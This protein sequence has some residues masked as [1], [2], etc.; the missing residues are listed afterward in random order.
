MSETD[1]H[2]P[3]ASGGVTAV[4]S[5][6]DKLVPVPLRRV[7][8][9]S[10]PEDFSP[11]RDMVPGPWVLAG[12]E[13]AWPDWEQYA[14]EL[15][16]K[17]VDEIRAADQLTGHIAQSMTAM[18]GE[19]LAKQHGSDRSPEF[20]YLLLIRW[21]LETV[22]TA[23]MRYR[24]AG[25]IIAATGSTASLSIE[26]PAADSAWAFADIA[27]MYNRG[28]CDRGFNAW[29]LA[30][31]LQRQTGGQLDWQEMAVSR[32]D[33]ESSGSPK[34]SLIRR[35][36]TAIKT[37]RCEV[38]NMASEY[39]LM[40]KVVSAASHLVLNSW[41]EIIP[42]KRDI[43]SYR[44]TVDPALRERIGA[45]LFDYLVDVLER[46]LPIPFSSEFSLNDDR[47]RKVR[48][49]KGRL[50]IKTISYQMSAERLFEAAHRIDQGEGLIHL[51]HGCNYGFARAYSLAS[52]IEYNQHA[53]LTWGWR[54]HG[55]YAGRFE[56]FPAP[57]LA[58]WLNSHRR[59]GNAILLVS[60]I[61]PFLPTRLISNGEL[62]CHDRRTD[63]A[64]FIRSVS[65]ELASDLL[66]RPYRQ[67]DHA[68]RDA[69]YF[70]K[71]FPGVRQISEQLEFYR[72]SRSCRVMVVDHPGLTFYQALIAGTPVIGFWTDL[73]WPID[74]DV[75]PMFDELRRVGLLFDT[76]QEAAQALNERAATFEDWW[77]GD[78]VQ[79]A[80]SAVKKCNMQSS[81]F[82]LPLWMKKIL[83]L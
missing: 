44:A 36:F 50:S 58:P 55:D 21:V 59:A 13:A 61:V 4:C 64:G 62:Y 24:E 17:T 10:I 27:D 35:A 29:L 79:A 16:V 77:Q 41:L 40:T 34:M 47:A 68:A 1:R 83:T 9:G 67:V 76:G 78:E 52:T 53:F 7:I 54:R 26:A 48:T 32:Q 18:F 73:H 71:E 20:W 46:S 72:V 81:R 28:I 38:G 70:R 66:Y 2:H 49:R 74:E 69:D 33:P 42:A 19:R 63:R 12:Q 8:A 80:V 15:P 23:W 39:N 37:G 43:R 25:M 82:W 51:Q 65:A 14:F 30:L 75:K 60:S 3:S 22:Q 11:D 5:E 56:S 31:A 57:Q 6:S 45:P